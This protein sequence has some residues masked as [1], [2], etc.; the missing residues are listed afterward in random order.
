MSFSFFVKRRPS[1]ERFPYDMR[2][3]LLKSLI[4][5]GRFSSL[6]ILSMWPYIPCSSLTLSWN[7]TS[8][9]FVRWK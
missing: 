5:S 1:S 9:A 3:R 2:R 8:S 4:S 7:S 6:T